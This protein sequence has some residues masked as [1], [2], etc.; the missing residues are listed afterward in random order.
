VTGGQYRLAVRLWYL[1]L[2]KELSNREI[3]QYKQDKTN[4]DYLMQVYNTGYYSRFFRL[5][6]HFE[7]SWYGH[8]EVDR[9]TYD[10][11]A[12]EFLQFENEI[13]PV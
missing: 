7:Y 6:R 5:T 3:I 11:I 8:F 2:L 9:L 1:R 4:L 10:R 13:K 12:S